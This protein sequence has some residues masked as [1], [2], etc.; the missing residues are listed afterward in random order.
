[1]GEGLGAGPVWSGLSVIAPPPPRTTIF[2]F[3]SVEVDLRLQGQLVTAE[4]MGNA[5]HV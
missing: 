5:E 2:A 1:M 3:T 4:V